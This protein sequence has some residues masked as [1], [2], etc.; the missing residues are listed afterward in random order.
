MD[1]SVWSIKMLD[2]SSVT[3]LTLLTDKKPRGGGRNCEISRVFHEN[4]IAA[5]Y[6]SGHRVYKFVKHWLPDDSTIHEINNLH[7]EAT[8]ILHSP[9]D[10]TYCISVKNSCV[11]QYISLNFGM[12][13]G[14]FIAKLSKKWYIIIPLTP[15]SSGVPNNNPEPTDTASSSVSTATVSS[16]TN[17]NIDTDRE[18]PDYTK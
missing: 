16:D 2:A 5:T 1:T 3:V 17:K 10:A 14:C 13:H 7:R 8:V 12:G 9:H 18:E 4:S 11:S 6:Q 15:E